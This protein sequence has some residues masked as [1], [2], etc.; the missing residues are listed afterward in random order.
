MTPTKEAQQPEPI[1][2]ISTR[3]IGAEMRSSYIDYA[4][5]VIV[6]RALPDVRDG[7]KPVHRRILF[8]MDEMGLKYNKPYKKSARV[9]GDVLGKYHPHGDSAVYDALVRMVQDFSLR[10]PLID[11]QGNFG[12]VDGDPAAAYRYTECRLARIADELLVDIDKNTVDFVENFDGS[13]E[14]PTVLP[15]RIPNLLVNGSTGIAVGMATNIPPHNLGEICDAVSAYIDNPEIETKELMG[16]IKG[17]DFP[18]GGIVRGR[19]GI[20]DYFETGRGSIRIQARTEIEEIRGKREAIIITELPYQVNKAHLLENIANLV[21]DKKIPDISDIRD[22]SDRRGMRAVIEVKR[23]GNANVVL[24]QLFKHTAMESSFGVIMLAL[25]DGRPRVLPVRRVL[26]HYLEHRKT[27]VVRRTRFEL[28]K[29]LDRAHILEG[30]L[31]ALKFIDKVIKIIRGAQDQAE[32]RKK[33]MKEFELSQVQAQ[34]ILDM[35]LHQLT[36]LS[37]TDIKAEHDGLL[38]LIEELRS[39]LANPKK[40]LSIIRKELA[41][42][43]DRY[44][45]ERRTAITAEAAELSLEDLI[46]KEEVVIT[47]SNGGYIKRIPLAT[48]RTQ[49]RGGKGVTGQSMKEADFIEHLFVTDSH[50]TLLMFT[51]RGKVYAMRAYEV[52]EGV[53]T[54]KGKAAVNLLHITGEEKIT[55]VKAIRSFDEKKGQESYLTMCTRAGTVKRTALKDFANIR[56]T[57]I[58]AITLLEGDVL[59]DVQRTSGGDEIV[60]GTLKGR[61]IRFPEKNVRVMGRQAKGVRGI[62]LAKGDEVIGMEF[63]PGGEETTLLTVCEHGYGK[64]TAL[65]EYRGQNR[66]GG[67]VI[68]IKATARNGEVIGIK[69][70]NDSDDLMVMTGGGMTIRL[71]CKDIKTISR[72]TQG[73]RIVRVKTGDVVARIAPVVRENGGKPAEP[74]AAQ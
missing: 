59:V 11:G 24:N 66:G 46:Q 52:P 49:G 9:V 2:S 61:A 57:G 50:A 41:A 20:F 32:A 22:E 70:V 5:S 38:K 62:R 56:R 35:R 4:M 12:S 1:G 58:A 53:R 43:K 13:M 48:Y 34:A 71:H 29:A 39:I 44:G 51:N 21:R 73:V 17:P 31:I 14:E 15:A 33:L 3:D 16:I 74:E 40:V 8:T 65:S 63:C 42:L 67:G 23:D 64:R 60:I 19:T 25:V 55:S 69:I 28:R 37:A 72:N 6:G 18:T 10:H 26:G 30:F 68:T 7:L 54:S 45:D 47:L 27:V 36:R